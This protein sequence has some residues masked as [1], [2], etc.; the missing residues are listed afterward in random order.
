[1]SIRR[2]VIMVFIGASLCLT[3]MSQSMALG[4]APMNNEQSSSVSEEKG[5]R[6]I[7]SLRVADYEAL[8]RASVEGKSAE[9][10]KALTRAIQET[11]A[12]VEKDVAGSGAVLLEVFKFTP[13]AVFNADTGGEEALRRH[14]LVLELQP[15]AVSRPF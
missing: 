4:K 5:G 2:M 12:K 15:D 14:P 7:V 6:F 10:D 11:A 8:K 1:M 13:A 9:A 3:F